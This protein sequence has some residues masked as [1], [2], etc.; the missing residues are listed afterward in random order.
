MNKKKG[1]IPNMKPPFKDKM[2]FNVFYPQE[3]T[4]IRDH[5]VSNPCLFPSEK[6]IPCRDNSNSNKSNTTK[7]YITKSIFSMQTNKKDK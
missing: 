6:S 7:N 4:F 3:K 2:I 5:M 1:V